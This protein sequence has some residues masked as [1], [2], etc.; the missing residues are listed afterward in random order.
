MVWFFKSKKS[1]NTIKKSKRVK[2]PTVLQMEAVECGAAALGM[3]LAYYGKYVP[4][5]ELRLKC[6]VSRDGSKASNIVKAARQYGLNAK[7]YRYE[8]HELRSQKLPIIIHWDFGHFLVLEGFK[9]NKYY[10]NDPSSGPRVVSEDEFDRSFTGVALKFEP[11]SG[12]KTGGEKTGVLKALEKRF[13]GS[14]AAVAFSVITGLALVI[15]GLIIPS[16]FRIFIDSI[17]LD[18]KIDWLYPLIFGMLLTALIRAVLTWLQKK[19]LLRLETKIAIKSSSEFLWHILRLPVVFFTQ[20]FAGEI[21][22]RMTSNNRVASLLSGQL[23]TVFLNVIVTLF[24]IILMLTYD[25][26]LTGICLLS[27]VLSILL[28]QYISKKRAI[29]NIKLLQDRGKL[30]GTAMYGLQ[31]IET[32]KATGSESDFFNKWSGIHARVMNAEQ[33][34]GKSSIVLMSVPLTLTLLS[35][36]LVLIIGS[37]RILDGYMSI[38]MLVAFQS[39]MQSF[40]AP[41]NELVSMASV[42][43]EVKGD[44]NRLD[45][46]MKYP[47][48]VPISKTSEVKTETNIKLQGFIE[49]KNLSF[50]YSNLEPPLIEDFSLKLKPGTRVAL[51]GGSGSGKST[52]VKIISGLYEKWSGE[53]LFDGI[54]REELPRF[55]IN[56]SLSIVDQDICMFEGTIKDNITLWDLTAEESDIINASKDACIH[57]D[58]SERDGGYESGIEEGGR[59]FSGGQ[60]QRIEIARALAVNPS[61]LILDEA[62]SALDPKTEKV[63]DENIRRRGCTCII[64]AHRLSTIRDCDEII[65]MNRG[66]IVQRGT[67]EEMKTV[68][69]PYLKLIGTN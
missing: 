48:D 16:F 28:M 21:S 20:R 47:V 3:I 57:E 25:S 10:L 41:L 55:V 13:K 23:A 14:E 19:Y 62:T 29:L 59:N 49:I 69:G 46:V 43:Q 60:R 39:L 53:I 2:V 9:K 58:I 42:L 4:L 38:G 54:K 7:G 40:T 26:V 5:E 15:P 44:M 33:D 24:F 37:Y 52:I 31:L 61:I 27:S 67:H 50:G 63:I 34:S 45:D 12:F 65:V 35:N 18:G 22:T 64:V 51:I 66:K 30:D 68:D 6:G 1:K 32:L 11:E 36:A 8:P 17:I 56:N